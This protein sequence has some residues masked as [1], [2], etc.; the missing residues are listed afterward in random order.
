M[1]DDIPGLHSAKRGNMGDTHG[2][3]EVVQP[4]CFRFNKQRFHCIIVQI[5][6]VKKP[7]LKKMVPGIAAG[8][9]I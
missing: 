4:I 1:G 2:S 5:P 6:Q 7:G 3:Y 8:D 9:H